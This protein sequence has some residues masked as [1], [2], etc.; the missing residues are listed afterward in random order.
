M[1]SV[2]TLAEIAAAR[3]ATT[4]IARVGGIVPSR[5]DFGAAVGSSR[6]EVAVLVELAGGAELV[7]LARSLDDA[8]VPALSVA[9]DSEIR[10]GTRELLAAVSREATA[11]LLMR[12]IVVTE[13][14]CH[15]ARLLGADAVALLPS[16]LADAEL[17]RLGRTIR[18][19]HMATVAECYTEEDARRALALGARIL[20]AEP[21]H[22]DGREDPSLPERI[23]RLTPPRQ[24]SLVASLP[25]A[26]P[27]DV[28]TLGG[29]CDAV[30]VS[31]AVTR[32]P[33][34]LDAYRSLCRHE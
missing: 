23:A 12:D 16:L 21:R 33:S 20:L 27:E 7:D 14:Q 15:E 22:P 25:Q 3:R 19:M 31:T 18:S 29:V 8:E 11:P 13:A 6:R 1:P 32:A 17:D 34:P 24:V 4:R 9:T 28:R 2:P 10:G 5:R 26:T 30:L